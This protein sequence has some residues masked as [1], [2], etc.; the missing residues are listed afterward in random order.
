MSGIKNIDGYANGDMTSVVRYPS[1]ITLRVFLN[2]TETAEIYTP[3][4]IIEYR[5]RS[6]AFIQTDNAMGSVTVSTEYAMDTDQFWSRVEV[7]F[8]GCVVFTG[9]LDDYEAVIVGLR[10]D[11]DDLAA[12]KAEYRNEQIGATSRMDAFFVQAS[13]AIPVSGGS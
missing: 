8:W 12:L 13:F 5:E 7:W 9:V 4:L 11:F 10:F 1:S 3:L 2:A 6:L